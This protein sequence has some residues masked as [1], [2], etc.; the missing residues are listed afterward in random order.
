[1]TVTRA[2][3]PTL[4]PTPARV[5]LVLVALATPAGA[6]SV[7]DEL[8]AAGTQAH[9]GSPSSLTVTDRLTGVFDVRSVQLRGDF[10]YSRLQFLSNVPGAN[11]ANSPGD[12]FLIS[13]SADWQATRHWD[14]GLEGDYSPP[15]A[16]TADSP[17]SVTGRTGDITVDG[18]LASQLSTVGGSV[19]AGFDTASSS[20]YQTYV[21]L[22]L[23]ATEYLLDQRIVAT[24]SNKLDEPVSS[25]APSKAAD[26]FQA[27][28]SASLDETIGDH[29]DLRL[30]GAYYLYDRDPTQV[31]YFAA[32]GGRVASREVQFGNGVAIA[33]WQFTVQ[34]ALT[35]FGHGLSATLSFQYGQ[36]VSD[37]AYSYDLNA[38][39]RLDYRIGKRVKLWLKA[40]GQRD[41]DSTGAVAWGGNGGLGLK[42]SF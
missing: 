41:V 9:A 1:M 19:W 17:V 35:V 13:L 31:G 39:L 24:W 12:V 37:Q 29:L 38:G 30:F 27:K 42:V 16:T 18:E 15:S 4:V 33:P 14:F 6:H 3:E 7:S 28:I 34:P 21:D 40:N 8:S 32:S 22:W 2:L 23:T 25:S 11:F 5:L 26:L 20:R 10:S 36:Y